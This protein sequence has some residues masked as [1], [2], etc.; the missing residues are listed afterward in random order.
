MKLLIADDD[1]ITCELLQ[2]SLRGQAYELR[3]ARG[4]AEVLRELENQDCRVVIADWDF[5]G[6]N[7]LDLVRE[8]RSG[9]FPGYIYVI[10]ITSR[11]GGAEMVA[12]L[13]AGAD[14]FI[15]KPLDPAELLV[16]IRA[17]ERVLALETRDVAIFALARLAE[18][19]DPET[20]THLERVRD[21]CR[22]LAEYLGRLPTYAAEIDA[23]YIR[24]IYATSPLHDIGKVGVPDR[25]LLKPGHLNDREYEIMKS[26]VELGAET[27]EAALGQFPHAKFLCMARDIAMTH[28]ERF[29][30]TGYPQGLK[31]EEIPL[32]G[33]IVALADVYDALTSKRVYKSAYSHEVAKSI[34]LEGTGSHFDP[35]VVEAFLQSEE[36]FLAV[37]SE[38]EDV[39]AELV[40]MA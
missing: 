23:E 2:N 3:H 39:T 24:L 29:D 8:I 21:Y 7:G 22:I 32:C 4:K 28:H 34:I 33:R 36:K 38:Q 16:R 37:V 14:D 19:R 1:E 25:I 13:D 9:N 27:L 5:P 18:S 31:G 30:G 40:E 15:R 20:G 11:E 17:G 35:D 26:H 10:L 6:M 12:G